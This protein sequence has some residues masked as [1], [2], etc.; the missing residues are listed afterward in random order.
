MNEQ[1]QPYLPA[2]NRLNDHQPQD[3][4][5]LYH[6]T[7]DSVTI[8]G[9]LKAIDSGRWYDILDAAHRHFSH[10]DVRATNNLDE[11]YGA[12]FKQ[13]IGVYGLAEDL[14]TFAQTTG[15]TR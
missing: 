15:V 8:R 6:E 9:K 13:W 2:S 14:N 1:Q 4:I 3:F 11:L 12:E 7:Q 10:S 5:D